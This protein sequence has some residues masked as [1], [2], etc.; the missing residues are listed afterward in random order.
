M[1]VP[2]TT[3]T[4]IHEFHVTMDFSFA[5]QRDYLEV[6]VLARSEQFF[7]MFRLQLLPTFYF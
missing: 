4:Y 3:W 6:L 7:F 5:K 1:A 2:Y